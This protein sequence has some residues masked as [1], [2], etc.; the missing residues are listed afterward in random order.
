MEN[1]IISQYRGF[2]ENSFNENE[3][4]KQDVDSKYGHEVE[5]VSRLTRRLNTMHQEFKEVQ[6]ELEVL[7][8]DRERLQKE[9]DN[10][11]MECANCDNL[12]E[13][14]RKLQKEVNEYRNNGSLSSQSRKIK[15]LEDER[16][17]IIAEVAEFKELQGELVKTNEDLLSRLEVEEMKSFKLEEELSTR[18]F[19]LEKAET[20]IKKLNDECEKLAKEL[21]KLEQESNNLKRDS[22]YSDKDY[23]DARKK[24]NDLEISKKTEERLREE[25]SGFKNKL[26]D[27]NET[28]NI[29][30][31]ELNQSIQQLIIEKTNLE[32][33]LEELEEKL[34]EIEK[35]SQERME[36]FYQSCQKNTELEENLARK[37][38]ETKRFIEEH[39]A[40]EMAREQ[41]VDHWRRQAEN[42]IRHLHN[43]QST[44]NSGKFV[45]KDTKIPLRDSKNIKKGPVARTKSPNKENSCTENIKNTSTLENLLQQVEESQLREAKLKKMLQEMVAEEAKNIERNLGRLSENTSLTRAEVEKWIMRNEEMEQKLIEMMNAN[46]CMRKVI[47]DLKKMVYIKSQQSD[48]QKECYEAMKKDLLN[49]IDFLTVQLVERNLMIH[50]DIIPQGQEVLSSTLSSAHQKIAELTEKINQANIY[51]E[52]NLSNYETEKNRHIS[53]LQEQENIKKEYIRAKNDLWHIRRQL[54]LETIPI[55]HQRY[56]SFSNH[57]DFEQSSTSIKTEG[58]TRRELE[59]IENI[60]DSTRSVLQA[61]RDLQLISD[62]YKYEITTLKNDNCLARENFDKLEK[63]NGFLKDIASKEKDEKI[64]LRTQFGDEIEQFKRKLEEVNVYAQDLAREKNILDEQFIRAKKEN[65]CMQAALE[66]ALI[67]VRTKDEELLRHKTDLEHTFEDLRINKDYKSQ[68]MSLQEIVENQDHTLKKLKGDISELEFLRSSL[69]ITRARP[70]REYGHSNRYRT[71]ELQDE[72]RYLLKENT[73]LRQTLDRMSQDKDINTRNR[74]ETDRSD[75]FQ[76]SVTSKEAYTD[77]LEKLLSQKNEIISQLEIEINDKAGVFTQETFRGH[78]NERDLSRR[79]EQEIVKLRKK[80]ETDKKSFQNRVKEFELILRF[81]EEKINTN[82]GAEFASLPGTDKMYSLIKELSQR[83][84]TLDEWLCGVSDKLETYCKSNYLSKLRENLAYNEICKLFSEMYAD[85]YDI[86]TV[87]TEINGTNPNMEALVPRLISALKRASLNSKSS[88]FTKEHIDLLLTATLKSQEMENSL[89]LRS[90][91]LSQV[92]K[93][94]DELVNTITHVEDRRSTSIDNKFILNVLQKF[95]RFF[96]SFFSDLQNDIH[97]ASSISRSLNEI[98]SKIPDAPK[99][100]LRPS[101]RSWEPPGY[102]N[103]LEILNDELNNI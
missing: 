36:L 69:D 83:N 42:V 86:R 9:L 79:L 82:I 100:T 35:M 88:L 60:S 91:N 1:I 2:L 55:G 44:D 57:E 73:E 102:I 89:L 7:R 47:P 80:K 26:A 71:E 24:M 81:I 49:A 64:R 46:L 51:A 23:V 92:S 99:T 10:R 5:K 68:V 48:E 103:Q 98:S 37:D 52:E 22:R 66:N 78:E 4:S 97:H 87:Q 17:T 11:D 38:E 34:N 40:K 6:Q 70:E 59:D 76:N 96:K 8:Q 93:K 53:T 32:G 90:R 3:A 101:P 56:T 29:Q 14:I 39:K 63:E 41:E 50:R 65:E 54:N 19:A 72:I 30:I 84:P 18:N 58:M 16:E 75:I 77:H 95:Q 43:L 62:N 85:N 67:D 13:K 45:A 61:I 15:T 33:A 74:S 25:I 31:N 27:L 28:K 94:A 20:I 12:D 21:L